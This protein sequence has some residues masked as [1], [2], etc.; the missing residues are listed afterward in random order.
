M[1]KKNLQFIL[2]CII[3]KLHSSSQYNNEIIYDLT[4]ILDKSENI[5][6]GKENYEIEELHDDFDN[7]FT[8]YNSAKNKKIDLELYSVL[9]KMYLHD[10]RDLY[11]ERRFTNSIYISIEHSKKIKD[12]EKRLLIKKNLKSLKK[13]LLK[14]MVEPFQ[15]NTKILFKKRRNIIQK[16]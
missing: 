5:L 1:K 12:I 11:E 13:I 3:F 7:L 4:K 10:N 15:K 9:K 2:F 14:T 16:K 8:Q 6:N